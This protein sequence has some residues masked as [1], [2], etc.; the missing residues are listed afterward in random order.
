M[1]GQLCTC[2][3]CFY[4]QCRRCFVDRLCF[5]PGLPYLFAL[6]LMSCSDTTTWTY[7]TSPIILIIPAHVLDQYALNLKHTASCMCH[8]VYIIY[9][10]LYVS[11]LTLVLSQTSCDLQRSSRNSWICRQ[12]HSSHKG[13]SWYTARVRATRS[14]KATYF[15][16]RLYVSVC[17]CLA[18]KVF[19]F[20]FY[21][22]GWV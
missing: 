16:I 7:S 10:A 4:Q 3:W 18:T 19:F 14:G 5:T 21:W 13:P 1:K 15:F 6:L 12:D 17:D 20:F 9:M 22:K 8:C 11:T 2:S